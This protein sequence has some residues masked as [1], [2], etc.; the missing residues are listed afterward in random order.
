MFAERNIVI[1]EDNPI[2]RSVLT[3]IFQE[4]GWRVRNAEDGFSALRAI[5]EEAPAVLLSDLEMDDM[6]GFELLSIIRRRFPFVR[7]V[8]MSGA[9]TGTAVPIGVA[10][11]GF[12]AKGGSVSTLLDL[13]AEVESRGSLEAR[14]TNIPVW[15]PAHLSESSPAGAFGVACSNCLRTVYLSRP[16][17]GSEAP[18]ACPY[19]QQ[20]VTLFLFQ[21]A[22]AVKSVTPIVLQSA[23]LQSSFA[24]TYRQGLLEAS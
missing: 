5:A 10:A 16:W 9:F 15:V 13:V 20:D 17:I 14:P 24:G 1:A 4:Y 19:C 12:Y 23:S 7:A 18:F 2:L 21:G 22:A 8:A 3:E 6:S 11:D